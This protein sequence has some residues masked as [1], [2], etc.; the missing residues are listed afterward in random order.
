MHIRTF[1]D[2]KSMQRF[3]NTYKYTL[4]MHELLLEVGF[5][6]KYEE[7]QEPTH[8]DGLDDIQDHRMHHQYR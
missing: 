1:K 6:V 4:V 7:R 8:L 2:R 5:G 3:I